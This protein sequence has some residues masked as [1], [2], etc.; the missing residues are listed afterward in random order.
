MAP[1]EDGDLTQIAVDT[2]VD[3]TGVPIVTLSGELDS[4]NAGSLEAAVA[5]ITAK[6]PERLIFDLS[7]LRFIDSAGIAVLIGVAGKVNTVRLRDPSP[8]VRRVI[9]I[10]G[11]SEVLQVEA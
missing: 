6:L 9:E 7:D 4:S 2:G 10:T 1:L 11:L 3:P 5:P 8:I